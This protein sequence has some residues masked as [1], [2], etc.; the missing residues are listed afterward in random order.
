MPAISATYPISV[1][2]YQQY[3]TVYR[4]THT[5]DVA[6][7]RVFVETVSFP[8]YN[9]LGEMVTHPIEAGSKVDIKV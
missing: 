7:G 2:T 3:D 5:K 1:V 4:Q 9:R 8:L 6:T